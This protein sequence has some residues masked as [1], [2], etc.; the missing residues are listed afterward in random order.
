MIGRDNGITRTQTSYSRGR[1]GGYLANLRQELRFTEAKGDGKEH[2]GQ[3]D[4]HG[5]PS[6][7]YNEAFARRFGS[8]TLGII[9][10]ACVVDIAIL[11]R[12]THKAADRN[13]VKRVDGMIRDRGTRTHASAGAAERSLFLQSIVILFTASPS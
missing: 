6:N 8:K 7:K 12:H 4:I 9:V 2:H 1:T 11:T 10:A 13:E 3:D 5:H